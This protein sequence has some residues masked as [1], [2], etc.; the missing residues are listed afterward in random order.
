MPSPSRSSCCLIDVSRVINAPARV[1]RDPVTFALPHTPV[2]SCVNPAI[3]RLQTPVHLDVY[4]Y[5]MALSFH[6]MASTCIFMSNLIKDP[7]RHSCTKLLGNQKP[8]TSHEH[9]LGNAHVG[10]TNTLNYGFI[11]TSPASSTPSTCPIAQYP[12]SLSSCSPH[13]PERPTS[14]LDP[15]RSKQCC[16]SHC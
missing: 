8:M 16:M 1:D 2:D 10:L 11:L 4:V 3:R 6:R 5:H 13:S 12:S 7:E 15:A 9:G 14:V